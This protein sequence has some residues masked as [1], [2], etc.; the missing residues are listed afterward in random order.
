M[1]Y[2]KYILKDMNDEIDTINIRI[3]WMRKYIYNDFV[4]NSLYDERYIEINK[5]NEMCIVKK[6]LFKEILDKPFHVF[7]D[8]NLLKLLF[9][10]YND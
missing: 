7:N 5:I 1:T 10:Y 4:D 9:E 3:K 6:R 2:Y 8:L